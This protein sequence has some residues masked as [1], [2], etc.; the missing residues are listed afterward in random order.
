MN[1]SDRV[2][3]YP[4]WK[5]HRNEFISVQNKG[6]DGWTDEIVKCT[7]CIDYPEIYRRVMDRSTSGN[8]G[9]AE[10]S[11]RGNVQI[12]HGFSGADYNGPRCRFTGVALP[13]PRPNTN[14]PFVRSLFEIM[15]SIST[16]V[17]APTHPGLQDGASNFDFFRYLSFAGRISGNNT[18]EN[19]TEAVSDPDNSLIL[20]HGDTGNPSDSSLTDV[21]L[22]S[23]WFVARPTGDPEAEDRMVR[24][25]NIAGQRKEVSDTMHRMIRN[26]ALVSVAKNWYDLQP[27][28]RKGEFNPRQFLQEGVCHGG[29]LLGPNPESHHACVFPTHPNRSV[30]LSCVVSAADKCV[31]HHEGDFVMF[32]ELIL[33]IAYGTENMKL[34][35]IIN[36]ITDMSTLPVGITMTELI[37]RYVFF[38]YT[39][40]PMPPL[41]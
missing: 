12:N 4:A 28:W 23:K 7:S 37:G 11:T 19:L 27:N 18:K 21:T 10:G 33:P 24:V 25:C 14:D 1:D 2:K 31:E 3:F 8:T 5:S 34:V 38:L 17:G 35:N 6:T 41:C 22:S 20:C 29:L 39:T 9:Q 36:D 30:D 13:Q 16:A 40:I 15:S 32:A 26:H